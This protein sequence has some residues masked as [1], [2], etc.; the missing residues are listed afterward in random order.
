[1]YVLDTLEAA[2]PLEVLSP[3]IRVSSRL[4]NHWRTALHSKDVG[5]QETSGLC[6]GIM[7]TSRERQKKGGKNRAK[8][9][10]WR[11]SEVKKAG[12]KKEV[13]K[14]QKCYCCRRRS[15]Y[16]ARPAA[17][18]GRRRSCAWPRGASK[19]SLSLSLSLL[20]SPPRCLCKWS[21]CVTTNYV[22]KVAAVCPGLLFL[23]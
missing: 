22:S 20:L 21:T 6:A 8:A 12:K 1:M 18:P 14:G 17:P 15:G 9:R 19:R 4:F 3:I 13:G 5:T 11:E 23:L 2:R 10:K 16:P 7:D